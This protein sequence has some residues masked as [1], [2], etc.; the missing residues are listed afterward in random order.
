MIE[1]PEQL[2]PIEKEFVGKKVLLIGDHPHAGRVGIV[3]RLDRAHA[4]NKW[5][6]VVRFDESKHD[7]CFVFHGKS[8]WKVLDEKPKFR[9]VFTDED[10]ANGWGK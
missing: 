5:G 7:E 10:R 3:N 8:E 2:K 4:I 6:F 1:I 9:F